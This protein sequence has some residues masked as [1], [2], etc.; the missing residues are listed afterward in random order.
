MKL[1][2]FQLGEDIEIEDK[3]KKQKV[4]RLVTNTSISLVSFGVM[5]STEKLKFDNEDSFC[6][7]VEWSKN[8]PI[9]YCWF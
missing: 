2:A 3:V 6:V 1:R 8:T 7:V 4:S 9:C 5:E